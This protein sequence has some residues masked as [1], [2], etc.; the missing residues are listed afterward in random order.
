MCSTYVRP[1]V[2][3]TYQLQLHNERILRTARCPYNVLTTVAQQMYGQTSQ[4]HTD[5]IRITKTNLLSSY[6]TLAS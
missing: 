1:D 4:Q 5:R 6:A 3:M 2:P